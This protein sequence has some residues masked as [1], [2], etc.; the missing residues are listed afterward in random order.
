M[1]TVLFSLF[2]VFSFAASA[3]WKGEHD[4]T[5]SSQLAKDVNG[6]DIMIKQAPKFVGRVQGT[7][8]SVYSSE[9]IKQMPTRSINKI[10]SMTLGV[11]SKN[12]ETPIIKGAVGGTA[13]YIDGVRIRTGTISLSGYN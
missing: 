11:E 3:Q 4:I 10:A 12:N 2:L 1:K 13:Y 7:I 9:D 8:G 5:T 6:E